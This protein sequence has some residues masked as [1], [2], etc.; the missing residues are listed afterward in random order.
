MCIQA[1][2]KGPE[3]YDRYA[4][5]TAGGRVLLN[6]SAQVR[7]WYSFRYAAASAGVGRGFGQVGLGSIT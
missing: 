4:K 5:S 3:I 1:I 6:K 7:R 2:K